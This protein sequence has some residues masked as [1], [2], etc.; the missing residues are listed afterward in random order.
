MDPCSSCTLLN[1][2]LNFLRRK[3]CLL[4]LQVHELLNVK[5]GSDQSC[6]TD[7]NSELVHQC[8]QTDATAQEPETESES[9]TC[10]SSGSI[11]NLNITHDR[12]NV[13]SYD[14]ENQELVEP[15]SII[16]GNPFEK[17][18]LISLDRSTVCTKNF[19]N[20]CVAYY[21]DHPYTYSGVTH[22][23]N[24]ISSNASLV[25]ILQHVKSVL[26]NINYN[27]ILIT[28]YPNG[29]YHLPY[30]FDDEESICDDSQIV[31]I[32]FGQSR[33]IKFRSISDRDSELTVNLSHGQVFTMSSR[34]QNF[35]E[36]CIP[37]DFSKQMRISITLRLLKPSE[38]IS[39]QEV[40]DVLLG[41]GDSEPDR[42]EHFLTSL[43]SKVSGPLTIDPLSHASQE[44]LAS[45]YI[46]SSMFRYLDEKKLSSTSQDSQV[47][48]YPG[49]TAGQMLTRFKAD[50]K[51][52]NINLNSVH[53]VVLMIGTNNVD[54]IVGDSTGEMYER[55]TKEIN[56]MLMYLKTNM[57]SA[58]IK[59]VNLLPRKSYQ[60]NLAVNSINQFLSRLSQQHENVHFINTELDR[61]LFSTVQGF[62]KS[63]YFISDTQRIYD[64]VHLN[65]DGLIRLAKHLKYIAHND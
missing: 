37:K 61:Q 49:A 18:D 15:C 55:T 32:S 38:I 11:S 3:I 7:I 53:K 46:S 51:A 10:T 9:A 20:R 5:S 57:P 64:N 22:T 23:P 41:L 45:V 62:R 48:F 63:Y 24:P 44:K 2:E 29:S 43:H 65:R 36:H 39:T 33:V 42:N 6:Q 14:V 50:P 35:F 17:F 27:S 1:K 59:V 21:G 54:G 52:A 58:T 28:K 12:L 34:S 47:F 40:C 16:P 8:C 60:R 26:P 30:H 56:E 31:T 25:K 4:N 13:F 19:N